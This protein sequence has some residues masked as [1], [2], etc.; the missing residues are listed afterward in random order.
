[1][2][3]PVAF[4]HLTV[5]PHHIDWNRHPAK[6][7][8]YLQALDFWQDS[9]RQAVTHCLQFTE[10]TQPQQRVTQLL[11]TAEKSL[12]YQVNP[13]EQS[14]E[15]QVL[16]SRPLHP[17]K[18][19]GQVNQTYIVAEHETGCWLIEQHVA[20]ER[21]L[22]EQLQEHWRCVSLEKPLL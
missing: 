2:R 9:I 13:L 18:A 5:S 1:D 16:G 20:Q 8:I 21:V 19:I 11:K 7:D 22:Y 12:P 14:L 17:L 4:L 6:T 15:N 3:F 10:E